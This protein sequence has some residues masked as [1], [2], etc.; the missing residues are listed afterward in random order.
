VASRASGADTV[1]DFVSSTSHTGEDG[2]AGA[3]ESESV[4]GG[5]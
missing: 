4:H 3:G 5:A 2:G 1:G